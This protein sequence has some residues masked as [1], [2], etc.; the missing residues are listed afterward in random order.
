MDPLVGVVGLI[1]EQYVGLHGRQKLVGAE[2]VMSLPARQHGGDGI[3]KGID[4]G[5]DFGAQ[6]A[7]GPPDGLVFARF[8]L[9][10]AL[11]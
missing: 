11:C 6:S 3:A 7:S 1:G 5:V 10:P 9:A 2:Q 8:F 4:Q